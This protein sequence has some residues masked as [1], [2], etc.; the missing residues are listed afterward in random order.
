[1]SN[2]QIFVEAWHIGSAPPEKFDADD[3]RQFERDHGVILPRDYVEAITQIGRPRLGG[4]LWDWVSEVD[5]SQ[6]LGE[7]PYRYHLQ[8]F[9]GPI[10]IRE[11]LLWHDAGMPRDLF[12]FASDSGGNQFA[13]SKTEMN[14][15]PD[16]ARNVYYWDH[17]FV[18]STWIAG[19]FNEWIGHYLP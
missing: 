10:E 1:M 14:E 7:G 9:H 19:S 8:D 13:F 15:A 2:F 11:S 18:S 16:V 6:P 3:L 17:D 12:P 4:D 5:E